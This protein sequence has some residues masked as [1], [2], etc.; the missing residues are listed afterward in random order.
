MGVG[1]GVGVGVPTLG[2]AARGGASGGTWAPARGVALDDDE[3]RRASDEGREASDEG[4]RA[5]DEGREAS[6]EG[7]L[8]SGAE[9]TWLGFGL[10]LTDPRVRV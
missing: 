1:V 4:R 2:A 3:G 9:A 7:W 8:G 10:G 6:D 5:S